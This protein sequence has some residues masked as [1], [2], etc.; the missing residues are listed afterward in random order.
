MMLKRVIL[1]LLFAVLP[2]C[3]WAYKAKNGDVTIT[4]I[5]CSYNNEPYLEE[6][7]KSLFEQDYP[8]WRMIYVNDCSQDKTGEL[9]QKL[10]KKYKMEARATIINNKQRIG[11]LANTFYAVHTLDPRN[12][13]VL[14]DGDDTFKNKKVLSKIARIYRNKKVWLTYGNY[15]AQ[16]KNAPGW[17]SDPC[18][19]FPEEVMK[20]RTFRQ[21][22]WI[23]YPLRTFYAK[24]FQ[25]IQEKD[26]KY[27]GQFMQVAWDAAMMYPML[28]MAS[29]GHIKFVDEVLYVYRVNT[30]AN[31]F[32]LRKPLMEE[33]GSYLKKQPPYAPLKNL[34]GL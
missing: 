19:A 29:Q 8:K 3:L 14:Y 34:Y 2:T 30:G 4:V 32:Y 25:S 16:P 24:L 17:F 5:V 11:G 6:N 21:H 15:E 7:L 26:L 12:V 31:D 27:K 18:H 1:G 13:V 33:I 20:N 28:E 23:A 22:P 10:V 9:A